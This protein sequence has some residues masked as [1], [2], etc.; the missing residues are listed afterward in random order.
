[1]KFGKI[2]KQEQSN[3]ILWAYIDYKALKRLM[4]GQGAQSADFRQALWSELERVNQAFVSAE[5]R[6]LADLTVHLSGERDSSGYFG[7]V[8][9][10]HRACV[11]NYVA[12][13]KAVKK[14]DKV[15]GT[16]LRQELLE[17]LFSL[18]FVRSLDHSFLFEE[19]WRCV[20]E[21]PSSASGALD[22][23]LA[24]SIRQG[25]DA[26]RRLKPD[27]VTEREIERMLGADGNPEAYFPKATRPPACSPDGSLSSVPS[28]WSE[29]PTLPAP[30]TRGPVSANGS[31]LGSAP[32]HIARPR[33]GAEGDLPLSHPVGHGLTAPLDRAR[34][35]GRVRGRLQ[36]PRDRTQ[37]P[38]ELGSGGR[39]SGA[40]PEL[41]NACIFDLTFE[42]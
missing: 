22:H 42:A 10:L 30:R 33:E 15:F 18:P 14:H 39:M 13:L 23:A 5:R 11:L 38:Q 16:P 25:F 3:G 40:E 8:E 24:A 32:I 12:A 26:M 6:Y 41:D 34:T 7:E 29:A 17:H 28:S 4:K 19:C 9:L 20:S 1:M 2:W 27:S 21:A 31:P 37:P 36:A 35:L